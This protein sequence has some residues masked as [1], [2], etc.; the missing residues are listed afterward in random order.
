MEGSFYLV[1]LN[2]HLNIQT[3]FFTWFSLSLSGLW[4]LLCASQLSREIN[5]VLV[6]VLQSDSSLIG[7]VLAMEIQKYV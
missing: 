2:S 5:W 1:L 3:L 6:S 4:I 7:Y